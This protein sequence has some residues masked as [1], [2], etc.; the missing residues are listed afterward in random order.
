MFVLRASRHER[1]TGHGR[2]GEQW[3]PGMGVVS[4]K[5]LNES[6]PRICTGAIVAIR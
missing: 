3:A 1:N 4:I 2:F 5:E 6:R